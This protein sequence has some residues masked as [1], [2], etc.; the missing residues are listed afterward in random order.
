MLDPLPQGDFESFESLAPT[1]RP[2]FAAEVGP[3]FLA[4][5]AA[6][7]LAWEAGE[8][9]TELEMGGQRYY[10]NTFKYPAQTLGILRQKYATV[11]DDAVLSAFLEETG[12]LSYLR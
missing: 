9:V 10:Q 11:A 5:D 2:I 4:W 7:A 8:K 3:R 1:L 6:N 12:C